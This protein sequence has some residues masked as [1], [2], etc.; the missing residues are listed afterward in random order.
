MTIKNAIQKSLVEQV[1][2][3]PFAMS[4]FFF[5][6]EYMET[7]SVE[8]AKHEVQVKFLPT[9]Q[10]GLCFWPIFQTLNFAFIPERNRVVAVSCASFLWTIFLSYMKQMDEER[11]KEK[12]LIHKSKKAS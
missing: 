5:S 2:Y 11:A 12:Q 4:V 6:M 1:T 7:R 3:G 10:I 9:Y 8:R